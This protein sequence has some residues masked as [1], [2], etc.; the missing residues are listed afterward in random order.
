MTGINGA[1]GVA[2][3][4]AEAVCEVVQAMSARVDGI[5]HVAREVSAVASQS[6]MLAINATIEAARAG[7]AGR[8]FSVVALE[9]KEPG[10]AYGRCD[11][12]TSWTS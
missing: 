2:A 8:G 7:E 6:R 12:I 5:A 11:P 1:I 10:R 4:G 9:G 3:H